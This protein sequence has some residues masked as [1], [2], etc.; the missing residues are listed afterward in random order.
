[1]FYQS[2]ENGSINRG[3]YSVNAKGKNKKEL[4]VATGTNSAAF[5]ADHSYYINT[6]QSATT[7]SVFT[8]HD[9][10]TAAVLKQLKDNTD[11]ASKVAGYYRV[12]PKYR[13]RQY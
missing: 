11:L 12:L 4:S 9:T 13:K 10:K 3:V 2:T 7:P 8:L 6:F 1:M 5:S